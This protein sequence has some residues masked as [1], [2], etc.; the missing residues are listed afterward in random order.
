MTLFSWRWRVNL[1]DYIFFAAELAIFYL[2]MA[3]LIECVGS[4]NIFFGF[5]VSGV[6]SRNTSVVARHTRK[7][8]FL[9]VGVK[10][11]L[12]QMLGAYPE[13]GSVGLLR[14]R[15]L[16]ELSDRG[17]VALG[18]WARGRAATRCLSVAGP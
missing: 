10:L 6:V 1:S 3:L 5:G 4:R 14:D 9:D 15:N 7:H 12:T 18:W 11:V 13:A 17:G 8:R 16:N 2:F